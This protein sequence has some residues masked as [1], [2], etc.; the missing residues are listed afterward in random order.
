MMSLPQMQGSLF[1]VVTEEE[2]NDQ[3]GRSC[4]CSGLGFIR[5]GYTAYADSAAG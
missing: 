2:S 3:A 1:A 5:S 4:F